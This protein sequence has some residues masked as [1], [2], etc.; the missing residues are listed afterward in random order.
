MFLFVELVNDNSQL[1]KYLFVVCWMESSPGEPLGVSGRAEYLDGDA[2][3][4][5][6]Y[7]LE[8]PY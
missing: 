5:P 1:C 6:G 8:V 4:R 3:K 7:L 2:S